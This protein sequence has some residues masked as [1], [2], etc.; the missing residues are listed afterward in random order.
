MLPLKIQTFVE[1]MLGGTIL[2]GVAA[3]GILWLGDPDTRA[4]LQKAFKRPGAPPQLNR[5]R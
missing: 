5:A 1:L 3:G 2:G 4:L